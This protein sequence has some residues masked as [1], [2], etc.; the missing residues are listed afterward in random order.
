MLLQNSRGRGPYLLQ[1]HI[2]TSA[3]KELARG[4]DFTSSSTRRVVYAL[5]CSPMVPVTLFTEALT[6]LFGLGPD[7]N[8]RVLDIGCGQG[9]LVEALRAEGYDAVG[10]DLAPTLGKEAPPYVVPIRVETTWKGSYKLLDGY[11]VP[12]EDGSFAA[13]VSVSTLEHV[14]NK[15][16]FFSEI[17]RLL[18]AGGAT[19]HAF[20]SRYYLPAEPHSY[21]PLVPMLWPNVPDWWFALWAMLGI[22]NEFQREESWREV[23]RHNARYSRDSLSYWPLTRYHQLLA[24]TGFRD[25]RNQF[26]FSVKHSTGGYA[27]LMR[28]PAMFAL[29]RAL[30]FVQ[31]LRNLFL[32][33]IKV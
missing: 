26:E 10:T 24:T 8:V 29:A 31:Q 11:K 20:P 32:T 4:S 17:H 9:E 28:N 19:V 21:V 1:I 27:R 16:V 6:E 3:Y 33:A 23:V 12:F 30:P 22:R 14:Q 15:Q 18:R 25:V 7:H 5:Q 2:C 13:V